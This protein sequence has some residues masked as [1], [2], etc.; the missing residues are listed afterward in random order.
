LLACSRGEKGFLIYYCE[1]GE[2]MER[3]GLT[4]SSSLLSVMLLPLALQ[5]VRDYIDPGTGSLV[6][7]VLIG[8]LIG[9]L[10]LI[11]V[12]WS[13]IKVFFSSLFSKSTEGDG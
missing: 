6:L 13:R 5:N 4:S 10:F 11:K 9:G 3:K 7:Q 8:S 12:F 2:I 1:R